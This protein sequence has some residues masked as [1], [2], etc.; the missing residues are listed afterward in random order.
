MSQANGYFTA[1][2]VFFAPFSGRG[3]VVK[4]SANKYPLTGRKLKKLI[5]DVHKKH[6]TATRLWVHVH[7]PYGAE[8]WAFRGGDVCRQSVDITL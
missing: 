6:P 4:Y 7:T 5:T 1:I 3:V 8:D 2:N